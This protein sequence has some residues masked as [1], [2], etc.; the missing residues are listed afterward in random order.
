MISG[1]AMR[2]TTNRVAG[3]FGCS[4][5]VVCLCLAFA[6]GFST[7]T[8]ADETADLKKRVQQLEEQL[9]D[10]QVVIG[11]LQSMNTGPVQGPS[12][13]YGPQGGSAGYGG[14][15]ASSDGRLDVIETQ[16]QA[17]TSQMEL[18][19]REVRS[20]TSD[21]RG[22][23]PTTPQNG[24]A[25]APQTAPQYGVE[26]QSL[27]DSVDYGGFGSTTVSRDQN[28][29]IG[30]LLSNGAANFG[31]GGSDAG[32]KQL[33]ETAYGYLL[34]QDYGAAEAAFR[35]FVQ[36][37]PNDALTGNAQYWLG[38]S[39][40]LRGQ[41]KPAASA[42]LEG[43]EKHRS[44][45]KAPESL[46]KLAMSLN[47]LGQHDAACSSFTEFSARFPDAPANV[48]QRAGL[49]RRRAGC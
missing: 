35:D 36:R 48:K 29:G 30:G 27:N 33:Y 38:E 17:L 21:R 14:G 4:C 16:I 6:G 22:A 46:L 47:K 26:K 12:A 19:S 18:L 1:A 37:Y 2:K 25:A 43:Y 8:F 24:Y 5:A 13:S 28:D 9:V 20:L 32:S 42:F 3:W 23:L 31:G 40:Y 11:T 10:M 49:E 44:N 34:Q 7:S 15:G 45:G 39:L 41:Y